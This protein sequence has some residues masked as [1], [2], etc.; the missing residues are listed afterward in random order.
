MS[1]IHDHG[2]T[3]WGC[4]RS[5]A[6]QNMLRL[7]SMKR[8]LHAEQRNADTGQIIHVNH[9]LVHQMG[10]CGHQPF[11]SL[12]VYGIDQLKTPQQSVTADSN[13]YY[14]YESSIASVSGG[15][16]FALPKKV[17]TKSKGPKADFSTYIRIIP[18]C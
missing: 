11:L 13:L 6:K 16:F 7:R 17:L 9:S 5:S 14:A 15:A 10:N 12:H 8:D 3:Q 2:N 18:K 4:V 1:A